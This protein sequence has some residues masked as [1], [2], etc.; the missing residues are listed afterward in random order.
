MTHTFLL[1][2]N[3]HKNHVDAKDFVR[4]YISDEFVEKN[5]EVFTKQVE[6]CAYLYQGECFSD[7]INPGLRKGTVSKKVESI[8]TCLVH[9]FSLHQ[10]LG[11]Q[12][13]M[14]RGIPKECLTSG[15][16]YD[17]AF[18]S[19]TPDPKVA[20]Y[21]SDAILK[22]T[23]TSRDKLLYFS[24]GRFYADTLE[25]IT[26][27]GTSYRVIGQEKIRN[28]FYVEVTS[29]GSSGLV[30]LSISNFDDKYVALFKQCRESVERG[31]SIVVHYVN[32]EP[33]AYTP[34]YINNLYSPENDEGWIYDFYMDLQT[35][36][37]EKIEIKGKSI[38]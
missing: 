8:I 6:D 37:L 9:A 23:F 22:I 5:D 20:E 15:V 32:Q 36:D 21:F 27:P 19:V 35:G 7:L 14:Y 4:D 25:F 33:Y 26:P 29:L 31:L 18:N 11:K 13:V 12:V 17:P 34:K 28:K 3:T 24:G 1:K 16:L 10:P 30:N 2:D 38:W